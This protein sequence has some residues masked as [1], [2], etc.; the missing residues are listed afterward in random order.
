[1]RIK[2]CVTGEFGRN[3]LKLCCQ[4]GEVGARAAR[5]GRGHPL[6]LLG[7][8]WLPDR[9][10]ALV[11]AVQPAARRALGDSRGPEPD[12]YE[13]GGREHAVLAAGDR[14]YLGVQRGGCCR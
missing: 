12:L 10:H 13:L 8:P 7:E 11:P 2:R 14:G 9:V 6:A 5:Q 1:M 3:I 4:G